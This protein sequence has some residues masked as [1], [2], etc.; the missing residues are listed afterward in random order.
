MS[1][2]KCLPKIPL[3][4]CV[5]CEL[6]SANDIS[7]LEGRLKTQ[8]ESLGLPEKQEKASKDVVKTILWDWFSFIA[9]HN[10]DHLRDKKKWY[11]KEKTV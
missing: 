10:T 5:R 8:V 1:K 6:V 4:G 9:T 3:V 2:E 7:R 11:K